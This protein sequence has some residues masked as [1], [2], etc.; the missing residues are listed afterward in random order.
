MRVEDQEVLLRIF[1]AEKE[2]DGS[3]PLY[4]SIVME[5]R[6]L[7]L[8]GAT[9]FRGMLGFGAHLHLRSAHNFSLIDDLP[10]VIEIVDSEEQIAR[11]IPFVESR[12]EKG[13]LT[14]ENVRVIKYSAR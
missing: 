9:V 5:A 12:M 10:I 8:K 11:L 13:V 3:K 6:R 14:T 4:E 1:V 2:H 7:H